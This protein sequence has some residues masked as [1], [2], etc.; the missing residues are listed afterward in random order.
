MLDKGTNIC[1]WSL[2]INS[3][4][5]LGRKQSI[6]CDTDAWQQSPTPHLNIFFSRSSLKFLVEQIMLHGRLNYASRSIIEMCC[7]VHIRY[8]LLN[9]CSMTLEWADILCSYR[10]L[11]PYIWSLHSTKKLL[12]QI[13]NSQLFSHSKSKKK[14][15]I[16]QSVYISN[17]KHWNA[18]CVVAIN[19]ATLGGLIPSR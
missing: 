8:F 12:G 3:T 15:H 7:Q 2:K 13:V 18:S 17:K 1:I 6:R 5:I 11:Y 10:L 4:I 19:Q 16:S 9:A 14:G